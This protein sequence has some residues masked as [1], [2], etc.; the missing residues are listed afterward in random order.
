MLKGKVAVITGGTEGSDLQ[1]L[2]NFWRTERPWC[3]SAP[4]RRR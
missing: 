1:L 2:K 4:G 3:C